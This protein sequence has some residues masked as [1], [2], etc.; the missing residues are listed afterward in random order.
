MKLYNF[1]LAPNGQRVQAFLNEKKITLETRQIN[2]RDGEQFKEPFKSMNPFNCIPFLELDDGTIIS[3]SIS[4]CR[5]LEEEHF[6]NPSLFGNNP[7]NKAYIDMW[8]RRL[9]LDCLT[10][11]GFALRNKVSMFADRVLAGTRN[12]IKQSPDVVERGM[13]MTNLLFERINPC[14][15]K[16]EFICGD[17]FSVADITGH[18]I[19]LYCERFKFE[20]PTKFEN[21]LKWKSKL[22]E[23]EC[24]KYE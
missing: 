18:S 11:L 20:I 16:N 7:Q 9:E 17:N 12:D 6:P 2:V 15:E 14:L 8:N 21:V 19:F 24:F 3:E 5:Y 1:S 13:Q 4:I 22:Y 23:R 10:P